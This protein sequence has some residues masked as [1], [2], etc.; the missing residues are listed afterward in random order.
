MLLQISPWHTSSSVLAGAKVSAPYVRFTAGY[1]NS[2]CLDV[3]KFGQN[4]GGERMFTVIEDEQDPGSVN[5][6]ARSKPSK[7]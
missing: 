2:G 5:A 6:L 1:L 3:A 7:S 4:E